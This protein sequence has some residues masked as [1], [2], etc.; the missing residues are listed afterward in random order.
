MH[1]SSMP[2]KAPPH[3]AQPCTCDRWGLPQRTTITADTWPP[4]SIRYDSVGA[5]TNVCNHTNTTCR[6][7]SCTGHAQRAGVDA[8]LPC[9]ACKRCSQKRHIGTGLPAE[10]TIATS[11]H[12]RRLALDPQALARGSGARAR[13]H[14]GRNRGAVRHVGVGAHD[15]ARILQRREDL[16]GRT[17]SVPASV[18]FF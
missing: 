2:E 6:V 4:H 16:R 15:A 3:P 12:G 11:L 13:G 14:A 10:H 8:A 17:L 18:S 9:I 5:A 7:L 1:G